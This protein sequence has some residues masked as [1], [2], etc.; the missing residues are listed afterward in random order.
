M[1]GRNVSK[2]WN[3]II[4]SLIFGLSAAATQKNQSSPG[5]NLQTAF[6]LINEL[7]E[8]FHRTENE[9]K[10]VESSAPSSKKTKYE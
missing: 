8:R 10:D 1:F 2:F 7:Q 3:W 9:C 4:Y 6:R 5:L